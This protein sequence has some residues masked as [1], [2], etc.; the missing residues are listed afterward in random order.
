MTSVDGNVRVADPQ[1]L[2]FKRSTRSI[3]LDNNELK[4]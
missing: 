4:Y 1:K 2:D 3:R